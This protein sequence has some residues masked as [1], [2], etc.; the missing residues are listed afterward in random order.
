MCSNSIFWLLC[1]TAGMFSAEHRQPVTCTGGLAAPALAAVA[2]S[3]ATSIS[4]AATRVCRQ[5]SLALCRRS[6]STSIGSSSRISC[7]RLRRKC[8]SCN[9]SAGLRGQRSMFCLLHRTIGMFS[10][11]HRQPSDLDRWLGRTSGVAAVAGSVAT[12]MSRAATGVCRQQS[13]ALCR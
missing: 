7:Y 2:G 11:E 10:A 8:C 9:S 12:S 5:H 3:V 13:L 1:C 4:S 6:C